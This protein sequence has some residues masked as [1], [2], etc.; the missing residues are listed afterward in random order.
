MAE[1]M[2]G[3]AAAVASFLASAPAGS[4]AAVAAGVTPKDRAACCAA[5]RAA[6]IVSVAC[7]DM[8]EDEG[9][10]AAVELDR[11]SVV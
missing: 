1:R 5:A 2:L 4:I 9:E 3:D 6:G 7:V 10:D 8:D 11:K